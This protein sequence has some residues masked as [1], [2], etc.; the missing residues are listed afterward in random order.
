MAASRAA[1]AALL[2]AA[3]LAGSARGEALYLHVVPIAAPAGASLGKD[4]PLRIAA[5]SQ[6]PDALASALGVVEGARGTDGSV[7]L[8]L[9]RYVA[10][11]GGPPDAYL[12][13]SFVVD[14]DVAQVR[15]L[16]EEL[17]ARHGERPAVAD[18]AAFTRDAITHKTL[19][20]GWDIA[21]QVAASRAG[22]CTEHAV[23]L[24]ALARSFGRP[25]RVATGL[26][27]VAEPA[28]LGAFGHA[29]S[30]VWSDGRWLPVD[31]TP[32]ADAA[33]LRYL[34]LFVLRDEGPG[35]AMGLAAGLQATWVQKVE[36]LGTGPAASR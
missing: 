28:R 25:A 20:R 1:V 10:L 16:R 13:A 2:L 27:I 8:D 35:Y 3:S 6:R 18:L 5:H 17:V 7:I 23:L 4:A 30:E 33:E 32:V 11:P 24:T 14:Y 15:A 34:P 36:I 21:S 29:W 9:S 12:D 31:A 26:V 22:D 19:G